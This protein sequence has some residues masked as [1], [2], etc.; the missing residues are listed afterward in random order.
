MT[1]QR[2]DS[3]MIS[4]SDGDYVLHSDAE[5]EIAAAEQRGAERGRLEERAAIVAWLRVT[6]DSDLYADE[7]A[8]FIERG[9]HHAHGHTTEGEG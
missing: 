9:D 3:G 6:D 4:D 2:Y 5:A 8:D 7:I 1:M